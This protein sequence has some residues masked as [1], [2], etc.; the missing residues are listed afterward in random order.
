MSHPNPYQTPNSDQSLPGSG[1][2]IPSR[3]PS[4]RRAVTIS[5]CSLCFAFILYACARAIHHDHHG[6]G[7]DPEFLL[8]GLFMLAIMASF[9]SG[10][11]AVVRGHRTQFFRTVLIVS[12]PLLISG[13]LLV[14]FFV[15]VYRGAT[16]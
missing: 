4:S 9:V 12:V 11:I 6:G 3:R 16:S 8:A 15:G 7:D 13:G 1:G 5:W 2:R 10:L 14:A